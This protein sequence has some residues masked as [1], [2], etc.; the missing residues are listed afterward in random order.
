MKHGACVHQWLHRTASQPCPSPLPAVPRLWDLRGR[1]RPW[2]WAGVCRAGEG[3][4][5]GLGSAGQGK[6]LGLGWGL[7]GPGAG[8]GEVLG[9]RQHCEAYPSALRPIPAP[10]GLS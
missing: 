1:G 7:W 5:P 2:A 4:E 9:L 3:L 10:R 8:Q 6:A